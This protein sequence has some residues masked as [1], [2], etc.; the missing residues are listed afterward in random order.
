M[1]QPSSLT[2][3]DFRGIPPNDK[4]EPGYYV[5]YTSPA[6]KFDDGTL[7]MDSWKIVQGT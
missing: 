3:P 1:H 5:D 7:I 4:N 6:A 2:L